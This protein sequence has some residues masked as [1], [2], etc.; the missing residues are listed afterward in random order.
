MK[1]TAKSWLAASLIASLLF[2]LVRPQL[3]A[4]INSQQI[5]GLYM[6]SQGVEAG[7]VVINSYRQ[8]EYR[9]ENKKKII[10]EDN[11]SHADP[12]ADGEY[13]VW[14]SQ[15]GPYWQVFRYSLVTGE[16]IQ[17][18]TSGNNANPKVSGERV[19]W[20][21]QVN[22]VWQVILFDGIRVK[23]MTTG[24]RPS[25]DVDVE[26][27]WLVYRQKTAGGGWKVYITALLTGRTI[28]LGEGYGPEF[29][30]DELVWWTQPGEVVI[31]R[32]Y[33]F[34]VELEPEATPSPEVTQ[35]ATESATVEP[36]PELSPSPEIVTEEDILEE[37]EI[38][39]PSGEVEEATEAGE[40]E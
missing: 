25:Q 28:D 35:E 9:F 3:A 40:L 19:V 37:L 21:K 6:A 26:G 20:E 1:K 4:A 27:D 34:G 2:L 29:I 31:R 24:S 36:T 30:G 18:T 17:L 10:T 13:I 39:T 12:D 15:L 5:E 7:T 38:A 33:Q 32:T 11:H 16:T 8:I 23:Q 14:I 22:G